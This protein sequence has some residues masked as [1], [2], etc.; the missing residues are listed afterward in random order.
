MARCARS[1]DVVCVRLRPRP[2]TPMIVVGD[3]GNRPSFQ[4][5]AGSSSRR[6]RF[7]RL[8]RCSTSCPVIA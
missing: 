8:V 2:P 3:E 6:M 5:A 1:R 7:F 4:I